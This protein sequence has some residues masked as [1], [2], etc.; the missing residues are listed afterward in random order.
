MNRQ[1]RTMRVFVDGSLERE[2]YFI[3]EKDSVR[4]FGDGI[5]PSGIYGTPYYMARIIA[6][7]AVMRRF[8]TNGDR[9][10][11]MCSGYRQGNH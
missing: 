9:V 8:G 4:V 10:E 5:I 1:V 2:L 6:E 7:K 11:I 3:Q